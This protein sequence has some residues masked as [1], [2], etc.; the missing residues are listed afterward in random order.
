MTT[1]ITG[2][3]GA[4]GRLLV[5]ELLARGQSVR[6][7]VRSL[8]SLPEIVKNHTN[9]SVIE[10]SILDLSNAEMI[11]HVQGCNAVVSCLGHNLT[12]KGMFGRPRRLVLTQLAV[13]AR[14]FGQMNQRSQLNS[15][16]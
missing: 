7:I 13:C 11:K 3:S 2:A 10:A 15:C 14:P 4:T 5:E 1:L 12:I 8:D 6:I 9:L 16:S